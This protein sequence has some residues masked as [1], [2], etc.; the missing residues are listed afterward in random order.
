MPNLSF[1]RTALK[2]HMNAIARGGAFVPEYYCMLFDAT[3]VLDGGLKRTLREEEHKCL[4]LHLFSCYTM[5]V[6]NE[7]LP[8]MSGAN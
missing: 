8:G 1:T 2:D 3:K 4:E 7:L 5:E 6:E